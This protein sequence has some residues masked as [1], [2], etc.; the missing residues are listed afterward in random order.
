VCTIQR[1]GAAPLVEAESAPSEGHAPLEEA[2]FTVE[3][4]VFH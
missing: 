3:F 2:G 1:G 4:T